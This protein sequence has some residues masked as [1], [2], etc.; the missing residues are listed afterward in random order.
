M[1]YW[2]WKHCKEVEGF[3][4]VY[5]AT[6]D[7]R[8]R[9]AA[10]SFGAKVVMTPADC[11]SPTERIRLVSKEVP[12]D[13]YV[14]VNGDEPLMTAEYIGRC[15]PEEDVSGRPFVMNLMTDCKDAVDAVDVTNIKVA[16]NS[17][18]YCVYLSRSPIPYPKGTSDFGY[19]KFVGVTGFTPE[20][21]EFFHSTP[22]GMLEKAEDVDELRFVENN[23]PLRFVNVHSD[24]LSV[25]TA[26][27]IAA[28]EQ[29]LSLLNKDL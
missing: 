3:S 14:M 9:K 12:A 1:V 21:L 8:I 10:D 13:F 11:D 16:T 20:A 5:I 29:K 24:T 7:D 15:I 27:D 19:Q 28:V 6:D 17:T 4:E 25:D 2:V 18:G 22:R 23:V 26:K